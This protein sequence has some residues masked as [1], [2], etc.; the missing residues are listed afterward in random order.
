VADRAKVLKLLETADNFVKYGGGTARSRDRA[1]KRYRRAEQ[2]AVELGDEELRARARLR[3]GD[4]AS[5]PAAPAGEGN[6]TGEEPGSIL[7]TDLPPHARDRVPPG[8][9]VKKGWPVL[10][11]GPIP[12]FDP[13][14]WDLKVWG[15]V[16]RPLEL[17][18]EALK[19]RPN[20]GM[21]S[22]FH[23]VTGWS[24]LDN[25]W[26][27]VSTRA[28]L[29]EARPANDATHVTVHAE[30]GY[31]ANLPLSVLLEDA[32]ILAWSHDGEDL[33]PKHGFP[34]RLVVPRLYAWKSV[35]W[36][37]GI[38]LLNEDVRGFWEVRGY[39]NRADPWLEER[40]SYQ[41]R[42]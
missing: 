13:A 19:G 1:E 36:V 21:R 6:E 35:K 11:E 31:T 12:R 29:E 24:R 14:T 32:S 28:L 9:R 20:V 4:L 37:R 40:Y 5:R 17:T 27:G 42:A 8:Q 7:L 15:L 10:H 3:L 2:L 25:E 41:E 23:C 26:T 33:A 16:E 18:Y 39:H 38:E 22:D 34:L 30:Y